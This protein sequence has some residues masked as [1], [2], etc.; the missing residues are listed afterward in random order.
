MK[1]LVVLTLVALTVSLTEGIRITKC[2]LRDY[3][4]KATALRLPPKAQHHMTNE[5]FVA[6]IVCHVERTSGFD[7]GAVN[8][9]NIDK[10]G[11]LA[12][13]KSGFNHMAE[14]TLYGVFQL[15]DHL[16]CKSGDSASVNICQ[17]DCADLIDDDINNDINCLEDIKT[18]LES[19]HEHREAVFQMAKLLFEMDCV[20][21]NASDYF[22]DC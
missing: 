18:E 22:S 12:T 13:G 10:D 3:L 1:V 11:K 5:D 19:S 20:H 4:T 16:I 9:V 14:W 15:S 6:K 8:T 21:V 17:M 7:T 2:E